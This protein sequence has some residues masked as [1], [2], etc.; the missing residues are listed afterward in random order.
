MTKRTRLIVQILGSGL[1]LTMSTIIGFAQTSG[2]ISGLVTDPSGAAV[3]GAS[4]TVTNKATRQR[5][6][7]QPIAKGSIRSRPCCPAS[8]N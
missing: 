8:T 1:L 2:E 5:A 3:S 4:V 7:S 6:R